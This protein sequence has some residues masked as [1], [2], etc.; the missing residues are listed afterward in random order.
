MK[1]QLE[2]WVF[3]KKESYKIKSIEPCC[4]EITHNPVID[5]RVVG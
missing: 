4:H 3:D 2:K 5:F 1:L